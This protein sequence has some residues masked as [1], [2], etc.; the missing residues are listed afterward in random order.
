MDKEMG[1]TS[2]FS[3][4]QNSTAI[5]AQDLQALNLEKMDQQFE[6]DLSSLGQVEADS[7]N[8]DFL[9]CPAPYELTLAV[10]NVPFAYLK[11]ITADFGACDSSRKIGSGGFAD[12]FLGITFRSGNNHV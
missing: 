2:D 5:T 6:D 11:R 12:V 9:T 10:P 8:S 3:T 1:M 4:S 7:D